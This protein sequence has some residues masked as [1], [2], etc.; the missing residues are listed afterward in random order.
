MVAKAMLQKMRTGAEDGVVVR[1]A[2]LSWREVVS[3]E[4]ISW[5]PASP[6][7][8]ATSDEGGASEA[9]AYCAFACNSKSSEGVADFRVSSAFLGVVQ[10]S[11]PLFSDD[12]KSA[13][14]RILSRS[15]SDKSRN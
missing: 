9:V 12:C 4:E 11:K 10:D 15:I 2:E 1:T 14:L 7:C 3:R 13:H 5:M 6:A 8:R